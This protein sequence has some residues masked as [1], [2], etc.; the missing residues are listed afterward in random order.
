MLIPN[1]FW[2]EHFSFVQGSLCVVGPTCSVIDSLHSTRDSCNCVGRNSVPVKTTAPL[3]SSSEGVCASGDIQCCGTLTSDDVK[4]TARVDASCRVVIVGSPLRRFLFWQ[5]RLEIKSTYVSTLRTVYKHAL[6]IVCTHW[7][8]WWGGEMLTL[9]SLSVANWNKLR[10]V[11]GMTLTGKTEV[12]REKPVALLLGPPRIPHGLVW[13]RNPGLHIE[14]L[15]MG[16][17]PEPWHKNGQ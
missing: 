5:I 1:L 17:P 2:T 13:V 12:L 7:D 8:H 14:R 16:Q 6:K 9:S 3:I 10:G 4:T 11:G 15:V